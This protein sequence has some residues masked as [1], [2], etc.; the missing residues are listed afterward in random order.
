MGSSSSEVCC[1]NNSNSEVC[2]VGDA[3][4]RGSSGST[5]T[6]RLTSLRRCVLAIKSNDSPAAV[7]ASPAIYPWHTRRCRMRLV[8]KPALQRLRAEAT[9]GFDGWWW[10]RCVGEDR[11]GRT[12][13][14]C[15]PLVLLAV[16]GG[17]WG[18][19]RRLAT[20]ASS[21]GPDSD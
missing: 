16:D 21:G 13:L 11:G 14:G 19:V 4:T 7:M 10:R 5:A 17:R 1:Q 9:V 8:A 3:A 18:N 15:H 12:K 2:C 6:E 20:S